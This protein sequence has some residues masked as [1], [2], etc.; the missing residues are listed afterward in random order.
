VISNYLLNLTFSIDQCGSPPSSRSIFRQQEGSGD[1]EPQGV[2]VQ[3]IREGLEH[4]TKSDILVQSHTLVQ[5]ASWK[6]RWEDCKS[7]W[8][9][10]TAGDRG[11]GGQ[12]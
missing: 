9:G 7:Q 11:W 5:R 3:R 10:K 2:K 4:V 8:L 12:L 1:R 6:K